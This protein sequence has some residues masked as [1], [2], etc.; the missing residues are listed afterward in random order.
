[1]TVRALAVSAVVTLALVLAM[2]WIYGLS[3]EN[4]LVLAPVA[5]IGGGVLLALLVLWTRIALGSL[6][7]FRRG[8]P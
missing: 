3:L 5:V 1:M 2:R 4:A 6:D 7:R 8:K